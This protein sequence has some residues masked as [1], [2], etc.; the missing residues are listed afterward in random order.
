MQTSLLPDDD[1]PSIGEQV[2]ASV[3]TGAAGHHSELWASA[4]HPL[5]PPAG[6]PAGEARSSRRLS[7]TWRHFFESTGAKAWAQ[8]AARR[9]EVQRRVREDG[10]TYNVYADGSQSTHEWPLELLPFIVQPPEWALIERG[11]LQ[12]VKLLNT[13]L[14]DLYGPQMLLRE[15]LLPPSLVLAHPQYLRPAHGIVPR[16]G[17]HLHIAAFDLARGPEG[18]WWVLA[19]RLQAPSGL[20][21]LVEN[22]IIVRHQF[23]EAFSAMHV[24]RLG[25]ALKG[26]LEGLLRLSAEGTAARVALLTPGP[27]SETYFEHVFLAR[28]LGVPL[29]EAGDLTVRGQR[30]YLKAMHGLEPVHVLL[31]RVDDEWLDP[32]ELRAESALGVPGLLQAVRAGHLVLANAPGS[33]VL[34][35]P[36]LTAFWPAVSQRLFGDDLLLPASTSWWCGES[37]VWQHQR[38]RLGDFVVARTFPAAG[39]GEPLVVAPQTESG[40]RALASVIDGDPAAY[41]LQA[42]VRPSQT[43]VWTDGSL[44]PRSAVVRVFACTDGRGGWHVLPGGLTRVESRL[45]GSPDPWLSM[46]RGNA[47]VDTWVITSGPLDDTSVLPTPLTAEQ[48]QG[49]DFAVTSRAAENL[50][51]MGRYAERAENSVRLARMILDTL[52]SATP[53]SLAMLGQ[54]AVGQGLVDA[55]VPSPVQSA[56]VFE[57]S[58]VEAL[59]DAKDSSSV[60][61]NL[62]A[63][64]ASA[65]ARRERMSPEHWR[66][67]CEAEDHFLQHFDSARLEGVASSDLAAVLART[68]THLSAITGAQTDRMTRDNGWR[69]LS[70]GRQIER[71]DT[72]ADTLATAFE[73]D[74]YNTDEGFGLLLQLFDSVITYRA[75]FQARREVLPLL[76]VVIFDTDNPRS[77][78]WVARTM[79]DRLRKLARTDAAWADE[80]LAKAPDPQ[81]WS[82]RA[83]G[84]VDDD[85]HYTL[86]VETLR[87]CIAGVRELS[88]QIG[89][90]LF[91]HVDSVHRAVW[92]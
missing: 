68:A 45:S 67:I 6:V 51:W 89:R 29:V 11:V 28:Y 72:L 56:R 33:G 36:G 46:Q 80:V 58:L 66:M 9:A 43:P 20:G 19:Q 24:Q 14:A 53:P 4:E 3:R 62:K 39:G 34:E 40:L 65:Q 84:T 2:V 37:A 27:L 54:L 57:R 88:D 75:Q 7:P 42:R 59:S 22:R 83:L 8:M 10:A 74:A 78:A 41:T 15:G 13:V 77:L 47:S 69:L 52:T 50:F 1:L 61:F 63:L 17:V 64:R 90:K 92:Q 12:R 71:L 21:Y 91:S 73:T 86:L 79:H 55:E 5:T 76:S 16:G 25:S 82:L 26:M 87:E 32:L 35:S 49:R 23:P 44:E 60:A 81:T 30:L 48:L 85:G 31:R 70:V 38:A 18:R